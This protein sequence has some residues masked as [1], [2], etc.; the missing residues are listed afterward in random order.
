MKKK[1]P[2]ILWMILLAALLIAGGI[3]IYTGLANYLNGT[4]LPHHSKQLAQSI[5]LMLC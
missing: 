4:R 1:S 5:A 3:L 2:F